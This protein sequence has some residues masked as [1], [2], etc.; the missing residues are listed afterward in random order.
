MFQ[1]SFLSYQNRAELSSWASPTS[2]SEDWLAACWLMMLLR[3][4]RILRLSKS[5]SSPGRDRQECLST[6]AGIKESPVIVLIA[7]NER[8]LLIT[9][10]IEKTVTLL[11]ADRQLLAIDVFLSI[12]GAAAESVIGSCSCSLL[13]SSPSTGS[14]SDSMVTTSVSVV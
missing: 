13:T 11:C 6:D 4:L 12:S 3:K 2:C 1:Q 7:E 9:C 10:Q 14:W 5:S 8:H